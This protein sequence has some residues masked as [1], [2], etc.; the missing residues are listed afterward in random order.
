[1]KTSFNIADKIS[2]FRIIL[3]PIIFLLI[4]L[5]EYIPAEFTIPMSQQIN[6]H[7]HIF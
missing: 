3:V 6:Y 4:I 5:G 1:M 7:F 2:I